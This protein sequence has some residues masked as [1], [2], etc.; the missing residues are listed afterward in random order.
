MQELSGCHHKE[1]LGEE[2]PEQLA[3]QYCQ[4]HLHV[5]A[6]C[7]ERV[8]DCQHKDFV[9]GIQISNQEMLAVIHGAA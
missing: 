2:C 8:S 9:R 3:C 4:R 6:S 7:H 1:H 5:A